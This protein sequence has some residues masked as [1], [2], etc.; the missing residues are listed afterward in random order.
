VGILELMEFNKCLDH[1]LL[2][3][4]QAT[5]LRN[6]PNNLLLEYLCGKSM[7]DLLGSQM[8]VLNFVELFTMNGAPLKNEED[9]MMEAQGVPFIGNYLNLDMLL[10]VE[11]MRTLAF[12]DDLPMED[13]VRTFLVICIYVIYLN[14]QVHLFRHN[15]HKLVTLSNGFY[16]CQ[17]N[18]ETVTYPNRFRPINLCRK[19]M[20][21]SLQNEKLKK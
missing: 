17:M 21:H 15:I 8:N 19:T 11:L 9:Q 16:S 14:L 20:E 18:A 3:E 13:K 4:G 5:K 10:N 2:A 1:L 12:L 6:C 7:A